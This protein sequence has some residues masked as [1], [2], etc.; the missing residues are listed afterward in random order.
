M[1]A[2]SSAY[3]DERPPEKYVIKRGMDAFDDLDI[4]DD[5]HVTVVRALVPVLKTLKK[6]GRPF[7]ILEMDTCTLKADELEFFIPPEQAREQ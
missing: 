4:P 7:S 6:R 1:N 3:W 2:M 5:A